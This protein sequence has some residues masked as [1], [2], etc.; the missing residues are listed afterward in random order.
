MLNIM[1][2]RPLLLSREICRDLCG[3]IEDITLRHLGI[4]LTRI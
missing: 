4:G 3:L 1:A 2:A